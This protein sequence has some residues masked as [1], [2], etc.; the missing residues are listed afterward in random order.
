MALRINDEGTE[1][2]VARLAEEAGETKTATVRQAVRREWERRDA[3][4][5]RQQ[6]TEMRRMFGTDA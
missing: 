1:R 5:R 4:R 2:L 3:Q 6:R